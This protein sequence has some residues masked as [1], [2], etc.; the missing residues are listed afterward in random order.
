[1]SPTLS[2]FLWVVH[3]VYQFTC[4]LLWR[5]DVDQAT[6]G[7]LQSTQHIVTK[8]ADRL[9]HWMSMICC[10]LEVRHFFCK[11]TT[12]CLPFLSATIHDLHVLMTI[13]GKQPERITG[14]PVVFIAIQNDG[15]VIANAPTTHEV[16][17][18]LLIYEITTNWILYINMPVEFDSSR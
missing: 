1:M 5:T 8:C 7:I 11:L 14:I 16:F 4:I 10:S 2:T 3:H 13:H 18:A 6:V 12:L 9:I 17:E 15:R